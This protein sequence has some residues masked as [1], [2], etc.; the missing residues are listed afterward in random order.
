MTEDFQEMAANVN[1]QLR[2]GRHR[3]ALEAAYKLRIAL[4][5]CDRTDD[6]IAQQLETAE[7][8]I[9]QLE[10]TNIGRFSRLAR[11]ITRSILGAFE[12]AAGD[13]EAEQPA[14]TVEGPVEDD[15]PVPIEPEP[16]DNET[17]TEEDAETNA[18]E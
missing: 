12:R 3:E 11:Y 1:T 13:E 2:F 18:A 10:R 9:E 15:E 4:Q 17:V 16:T 6:R 5:L 8:V 14:P 7:E